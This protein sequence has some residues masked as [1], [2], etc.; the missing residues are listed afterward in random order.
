MELSADDKAAFCDDLRFAIAQLEPVALGKKSTLEVK[1]LVDAY[2]VFGYH[3]DDIIDPRDQLVMFTRIRNEMMSILHSM[4]SKG[5]YTNAIIMRDRL[6]TIKADFIALQTTYEKRRQGIENGHFADAVSLVRDQH[7]KKWLAKQRDVEA[8][9]NV[10]RQELAKTQQIQTR[11][12]EDY[13]DRLPDPHV[14]Y[15]RTLLELKNSEYYLSKLQL[16]EQ[17]KNVYT[18]A[19]AMEKFEKTKCA[20]EHHRAKQKQRDDLRVQHE[21]ERRQLEEVLT[22]KKYGSYRAQDWDTKREAQRL[23]SLKRD[24]H[25]SHTLEL[26]KPPEF[27][28]HP[29]SAPRVNYQATS[30]SYGGQHFL[31][32]VRGARL[33]VQSLCALHDAEES[34]PLPSGSI[35]YH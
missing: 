15:S 17:A 5:K 8:D 24:M 10:R 27:S 3:S 11:Q 34:G 9:C 31:G 20:Q 33:Q 14:K 28:T 1:N 4:T 12:L 32:A 19:D 13:L 7:E 6:R 35:V 21:I 23:K 26:Q 22:E 18:R 30:S 2:A 29:L 16:F 25:H